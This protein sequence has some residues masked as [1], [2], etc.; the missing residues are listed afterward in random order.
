V[1]AVVVHKNA[2]SIERESGEPICR[3]GPCREGSVSYRGGLA[4][5]RRASVALQAYDLADATLAQ[6]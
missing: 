5:P 2:T 6:S 4:P 1:K 3:V